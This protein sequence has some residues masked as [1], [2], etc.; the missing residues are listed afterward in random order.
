LKFYNYLFYLWYRFAKNWS[1]PS[2]KYYACFALSFVETMF[3]AMGFKYLMLYKILLIEQNKGDFLFLFYV[4]LTLTF[5]VLHW[6]LFIRNNKI[7]QIISHYQKQ[8][9]G[10]QISFYTAIIVILS[11]ILIYHTVLLPVSFAD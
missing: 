9:K 5:F 8:E 2:P 7:D 1:N 11:V 4:V 3:I 6:R 10:A